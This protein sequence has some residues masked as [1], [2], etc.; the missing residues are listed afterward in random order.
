MDIYNAEVQV[1]KLLNYVKSLSD[2]KPRMYQKSK[3]RLKNLA[4]TCNQVVTVISEILQDEAL[5]DDQDEFGSSNNNDF[6][7]VLS[8][9]ED[10]LSELKRFLRS[11]NTSVPSVSSN[12]N[13]VPSSIKKAAIIKYKNCLNALA[14]S[15]IAVIEAED[16]G[17]L[18]WNWFRTRFIEKPEG[19]KYNM[20]RLPGWIR[21][22]VV[23]YC[24]HL[25]N[26]TII[27]FKS[28][29]NR[30]L[31]NVSTG[32]RY[33]VPYEIYQFDKNPSP[34]IATLSSVVMWDILLD[35]GLRDLCF[36]DSSEIYLSEDCVYSLVGKLN[37]A[38]M[39]PYQNYLYDQSILTKCKF[40]LK[41]GEIR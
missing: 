19:F 6:N 27:D 18:L 10:Q 26:D 12:T 13:S 40:S 24:Y 17:Q 5:V 16:C 39:D 23:I 11:P 4:L 33:A 29:F 15:D 32:N 14:R 1:N 2:N 34:D 30:W 28:E 3:D 21:D 35:Y 8:S 9:M 38:V 25:E 20:K 31:L 37:S 41:G 7:A 22:I 36:E